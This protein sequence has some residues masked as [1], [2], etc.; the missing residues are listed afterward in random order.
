M[1]LSIR[2]ISLALFALLSLANVT[3]AKEGKYKDVNAKTFQRYLEKENTILID[4]RSQEEFEEGHLKNAK[5][6]NFNSDDFVE[7][8]EQ[9]PKSKTVCIYCRSGNRSRRAK[10][11]LKEAG[12]RHVINLKKGIKGWKKKGKPVVI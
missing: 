9:F 4:I 2:I 7:K 1:T 8:M 3:T 11:V 5:L 6:V 10:E 12:F